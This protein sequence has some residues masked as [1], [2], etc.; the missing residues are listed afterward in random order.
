MSRFLEIARKAAARRARLPDG[1]NDSRPRDREHGAR[2]FQVLTVTS[3]KGGVGKTTVATN[4]AVYFR[5][6]REDLPI[7][8]LGLDDQTTIDRMF[9]FDSETPRETMTG[10]LRSGSFA[11]AIQLGQYGVHYVPSGSDIAD[12]KREIS[13]PFHLRTVLQRTDWHGLIIIDT[14]SDLEIL[15]QNAIAASD[16]TVTVVTDHA[17]LTEAQKVFGLLDKWK[18]PRERARIL[19]S[20]VDRRIKYR[21]AESGDVLSLLVAEIRRRGYPLFE[22]FVSRS[23]KVESLQTNPDGR[24]LSILCAGR[25][26]L[27]QRQMRHL[28]DDVLDA[29][30]ESAP[31]G[32][33]P[34][35]LVAAASR[36]LRG[37]SEELWGD[38]QLNPTPTLEHASPS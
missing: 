16:L 15:S 33:T 18:R 37:D 27:V 20:L 25:R 21:D 38:R 34:G 11:S 2:P 30:E 12:L 6:L 26:S 5:A 22:S 13:D 8:I 7:L 9:A 23:P 19:L 3:N 1:W 10:A 29:L 14:K 24:A 4:L 36:L 31:A 17:S 35:S 32:A 28:A